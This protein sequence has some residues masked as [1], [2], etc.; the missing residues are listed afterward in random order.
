MAEPRWIPALWPAPPGVRALTTTRVGGCSRPPFAALNLGDAVGDDPQ[1][2]AANRRRLIEAAGL[3]EPP[4][5]LEQVHGTRVVAAHEGRGPEAADAAWTDRPGVVCAV[6]TADCLPVVL[7]AGDGT[8]VAVAHAGWRG[9]SAG[10][11]EAAVA[12]LPAPPGALRAWLGPAIG[13][14]AFEVGPEVEAAFRRDDP[15]A[16]AAF[17]PGRGGRRYADLYALARRRLARAGVGR[18][19]GGAWCTYAAR[20][21]LFSH[22]RDGGRTGRMATLVYR[23]PR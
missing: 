20:E 17:A 12:A 8:A 15:G 14:G 6:L 16:A 9:L 3:P 11:L 19:A 22:R 4:R 10:V 13:A 1:A 23:A 2:V 5:W 21:W 7:A 18:V